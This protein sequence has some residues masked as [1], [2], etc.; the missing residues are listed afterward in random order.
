V[1]RTAVEN[2]T[3]RRIQT[4]EGDLI[5]TADIRTL[6]ANSSS[7]AGVISGVFAGMFGTLKTWA[8]RAQ[9]RRDLAELS[10][11]EID[12]IGLDADELALEIAKPFWR[13]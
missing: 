12:D 13:A 10:P 11:R 9:A 1:E 6:N 4:D 5:M 8:E 3:P 2:G 7:D